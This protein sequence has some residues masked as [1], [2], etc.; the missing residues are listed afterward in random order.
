MFEISFGELLV[1]FVIALVVLGPERLP[2]VARTL[3][4][5]MGRL[6]RY[7]ADVKMD[8]AREAELSELRQ[9]QQDTTEALSEVNQQFTAQM[10][11]VEQ[12]FT[13]VGQTIHQTATDTQDELNRVL[14]EADAPT[15]PEPKRA[16]LLSPDP[17]EESAPSIRDEEPPAQT[18]PAPIV[19]RAAPS[20]DIKDAQPA[21]DTPPAADTAP[22]VDERQLS[23][24]DEPAPT[25]TP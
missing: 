21:A 3:G 23:L 12:S 11:E 2:K 17:V 13:E 6:Q 8:L 19:P 16:A 20:A 25:K 1:I 7:V 14:V 9:L 10:R 18:E 22:E 4:A 5:M 15:T 24:F